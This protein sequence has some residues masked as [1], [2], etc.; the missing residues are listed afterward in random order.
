VGRGKEADLVIPGLGEVLVPEHMPQGV[1]GFAV[2]RTLGDKFQIRGSITVGITVKFP[3]KVLKKGPR[4]GDT[5]QKLGQIDTNTG[6]SAVTGKGVDPYF[7][8]I[9]PGI[10]GPTLWQG[11]SIPT[12]KAKKQPFFNYRPV[13]RVRGIFLDRTRAQTFLFIKIFYL[14][15]R[16]LFFEKNKN[17]LEAQAVV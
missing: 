15:W 6:L 4:G 9:P 7:H 13:F 12:S 10:C 17:S 16:I 3:A 8:Q 11:L 5:L 2:E 14:Q 1:G